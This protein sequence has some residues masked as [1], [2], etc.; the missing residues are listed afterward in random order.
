[1]KAISD[2]RVRLAENIDAEEITSLLFVAKRLGQARLPDLRDGPLALY[3][4][5]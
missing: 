5:P 1:M 2:I 3:F 4:Q